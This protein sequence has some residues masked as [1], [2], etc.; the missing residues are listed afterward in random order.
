MYV[1]LY[2]CMH[3]LIHVY[4]YTCTHVYTQTGAKRQE[5][6]ELADAE[7]MIPALAKLSVIQAAQRTRQATCA[8]CVFVCVCVCV[9][10]CV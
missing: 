9:C 2:V 3:I 7:A 8:P 10:V 4:V 1:R 5:P 6:E